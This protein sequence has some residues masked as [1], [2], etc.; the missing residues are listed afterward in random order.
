MSTDQPV[1]SEFKDGVLTLTLNRPKAN[2]FNFEMIS[3]LSQALKNAGRDS[4]V[5]IILLT[6]SGTIFSA[7]QDVREFG[8]AAEAGQLSFRQHLQRTYNPLIL[9]IRQI[10]KPVLAAINGPVAGAALGVA[11][12]CDLRIASDTARIVVGFLGIGLAP[13]SGVSLFLPRMIGLGRACEVSFSNLPI[14]AE[15][16][17]E[18]GLVNR[19]VPA[20]ELQQHALAWAIELAQGPVI[21]M[22][23]TKRAFNK[24]IFSDLEGVL[25]Y[26]AHIQE[27]AGHGQDHREGLAAFI[28]K[29]PPRYL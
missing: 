23:L 7:G 29:R 8:Q 20:N 27:I 21:A 1:L 4:N 10:E 16:A 24:S 22:G 5:R 17:L 13:D 14:S 3:A 25:D 28:E 2:A 12:A 11:L 6:G 26:E 19:V 18:W 15:Q 9:Q